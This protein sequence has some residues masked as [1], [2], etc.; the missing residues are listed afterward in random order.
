MKKLILVIM[1][2]LSGCGKKDA[3]MIPP[4]AVDQDCPIYDACTHPTVTAPQLYECKAFQYIKTYGDGQRLPDSFYQGAICAV[5]TEDYI[6]SPTCDP[7]VNPDATCQGGPGGTDYP[8]CSY[9]QGPGPAYPL[10]FEQ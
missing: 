3:P 8:C 1:L 6:T 2:V 10:P 7:A 9:S 4:V 5:V